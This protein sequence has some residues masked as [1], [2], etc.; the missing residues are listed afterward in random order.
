[1][2]TGA[3]AGGM[4]GKG[5]LIGVGAGCGCLS[6]IG[7]VLLLLL[8]LGAVSPPAPPQAGPAQ[9]PPA[10]GQPPAQP[11]PGVP[12]PAQGQPPAPGGALQVLLT[13][14]KLDENR[15]IIEETDVFSTRDHV[16]AIARWQA[17]PDNVD[18][19]TVWIKLDGDHVVPLNQPRHNTLG[20][21]DVGK[22]ELYWIAQVPAGNY[23][24]V[25]F[26]P[27]QGD[28]VHVVAIHKFV[29]Q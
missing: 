23:A 21:Q 8:I 18:L 10:Q 29:I 27:G 16:G 28:Q 4:G 7:A 9:R 17:I 3:P 25:V 5:V 14:A 26:V 19:Q 22:A 12:Q 6:I 15:H 1:M 2:S 20:P 24:F 11:G 13:L